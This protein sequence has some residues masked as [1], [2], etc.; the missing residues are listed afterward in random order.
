MPAFIIAEID[1]TDPAGFEA[2]RKLVAPTIA[3]A[4]GEYR[5]RGGAL[6]V[7]EGEWKPRRLVILEFA[8]MA[9]ARAWYESDVYAPVKAIR[10]KSARTNVV[11]VEGL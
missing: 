7:L 9:A 6:D 4:G 5:V 8:S 1:V 2:Y 11:L 3:D 10:Q